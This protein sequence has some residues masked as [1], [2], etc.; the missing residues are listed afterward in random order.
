MGNILRNHW[1]PLDQTGQVSGSADCGI[2]R[3]LQMDDGKVHPQGVGTGGEGGLWDGST[4]Q[5]F[6]GGSRGG[7]SH[8]ASLVGAALPGGLG[9]PT[10]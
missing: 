7:Y 10:H 5:G 8:D 4:V 3:D 2:G 6:G 9:I 1:R